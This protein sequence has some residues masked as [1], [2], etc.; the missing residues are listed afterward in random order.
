MPSIPTAFRAM[1]TY[2]DTNGTTSRLETIALDDLTAG[3]LL[4]RV[5]WS[6]LNYKDS[7]AVTGKA[8]ILEGSPRIPGIELVGEVLSGEA[9]GIAPGTTVLVHGFQTGIRYDG[10]FSEIARVPAAHAV[11]VPAGLSPREAAVLGVPAFTAGLAL[12]RFSAMG[13]TPASGTVAVSGATGAVGMMAITVLKRAG[14][15]VAALTRKADNTAMLHKLGA[16]EVITAADYENA[17]RPLETARF[18]A[19]MDNVGG[20]TLAWMLRSLNDAGMLASIGNTTGNDYPGNVLPFILRNATMI[21]IQAN[22]SPEVRRQVWGKLGAEWKPDLSVLEP[23]IHQINLDELADHCARQVD[24]KTS[25][26]TLL[27]LAD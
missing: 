24:G 15:R 19:A 9:Q 1:R 21:G 10:G 25:G 4:V 20:A 27:R 16:D 7:L 17:N 3:E 18:A 22:A 5:N 14:Y 23:H 26:R 12:Q 11:P 2:R 6:G 8:K 13:L